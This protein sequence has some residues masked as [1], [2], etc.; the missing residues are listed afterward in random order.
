MDKPAN[1]STTAKLEETS[2]ANDVRQR[3]HLNREEEAGAEL[4]LGDF[5][6]VHT[7][8]ISE[9]RLITDAIFQARKRMGKKH[10]ETEAL[11]KMQEYMDTY[12]RFKSK[13]ILDELENLMNLHPEL[14]SFEKSQLS[15]FYP[16]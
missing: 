6:H 5:Q 2:H 12:A 4:R 13:P 16:V 10:M 14:E 7:L 9:A 1:R 8:S 3:E 11:V 15:K